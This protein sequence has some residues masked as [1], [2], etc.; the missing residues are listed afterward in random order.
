MFSLVIFGLFIIFSS[1]LGNVSA[2]PVT[3]INNGSSDNGS[4]V[5]FSSTYV[6]QNTDQVKVNVTRPKVNTTY[7]ALNAVNV[8]IN[9]PINITFTEPIKL[10]SDPWIELTTDK[11]TFVPY[12]LK[13]SGNVLLISHPNLAYGKSYEVILHGSCVTNLSGIGMTLYS[14]KF[15]TIT[16]PVVLSSNPSNNAVNIPTN[17]VIQIKFNRPIEY[18]NSSAIQF[19]NSKGTAI[20][21]TSTITGNTLN[22]TPTSLLAHGTKYTITLHTNSIKDLAGNGLAVC[23]TKFTTIINTKTITA[24][25]VTF[26]YPA[27]WI[28]ETQTRDG[29]NLIF[30]LNP[31]NVGQNAPQAIMQIIPNP[32]GMSDAEAMQ[33]IQT[34]T[35]PSG[36]KVLVKKMIT[37]NGVKAYDTIFTINN[38]GMYTEIME[39][40]EIDIVKNNKTYSLVLIA[41]AKDFN[42]VKTNFDIIISSLKIS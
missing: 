34:S 6:P 23:S 1:G 30:A 24:Y 2:A 4:A 42:S 28:T 18:G 20:P 36:F 26:N 7:P 38:K 35:Y 5:L 15:T 13:V 10:N 39:N 16:R 22:I 19:I 3:T 29:T 14:T 9:K 31:K 17:K 8:P 12:G 27:T 40:Q 41:P 32:S 37:L 11:G 33:L 21:F 25:G